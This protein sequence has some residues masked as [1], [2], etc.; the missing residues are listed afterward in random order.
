[1]WLSLISIYTVVGMH[2]IWYCIYSCDM[3]LLIIINRLKHLCGFNEVKHVCVVSS[4]QMKIR[5]LLCLRW[6]WTGGKH[7]VWSCINGEKLRNHL[8]S[9]PIISI[10][11]NPYLVDTKRKDT[12]LWFF[13]WAFTIPTMTEQRV[14]IV[15]RLNGNYLGLD[16]QLDNVDNQWWC[17]VMKTQ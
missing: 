17:V 2:S 12:Y 3:K 10:Q 6:Q 7:P 15:H 11:E 5:D 8:R 16:E 14:W 13:R 9:V 1:M 4:V